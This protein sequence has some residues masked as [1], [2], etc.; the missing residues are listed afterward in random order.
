MCPSSCAPPEVPRAPGCRH[1]V[2]GKQSSVRGG[3]ALTW[4]S[5]G[6]WGSNQQVGQ[7]EGEGLLVTGT[8]WAWG[9]VRTGG[10]RT[11]RACLLHPES[12][13]SSSSIPPLEPFLAEGRGSGE[14][15]HTRALGMVFPPSPLGSAL[16]RALA[17]WALDRGSACGPLQ[18]LGVR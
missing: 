9:L 17:V 18:H 3:A 16:K 12:L 1:R 10:S 13:S 7:G 11:A 5:R 15:G 8:A 6:G 14:L 2:P 4:A